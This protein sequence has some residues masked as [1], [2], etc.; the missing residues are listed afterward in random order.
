MKKTIAILLTLCLCI[1]LCAC[2]KSDN[3]GGRPDGIS[4]WDTTPDDKCVSHPSSFC[5]RFSWLGQNAA[6]V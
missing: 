4:N 2:A 5:I 6:P 1:G 3:V